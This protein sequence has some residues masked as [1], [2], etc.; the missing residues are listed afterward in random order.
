ME[1]G[2]IKQLEIGGNTRDSISPV[3]LGPTES[4]TVRFQPTVLDGLMKALLL[5]LGATAMMPSAAPVD[6]R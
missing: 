6:M 1:Q 3:N 4:L 2:L 5:T